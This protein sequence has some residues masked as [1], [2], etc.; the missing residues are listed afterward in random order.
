MDYMFSDCHSLT[1]L[2]LSHFYTNNVEKMNN[3]FKGCS[4]LKYLN[5]SS[6]IFKITSNLNMSNMFS[7]CSSLIELDIKNFAT[8]T[9]AIIDNIFKGISKNIILCNKN[10]A[11][12]KL[13]TS[14]EYKIVKC[15]EE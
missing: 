4:S 11:F 2:D 7:G 15:S 6:F 12:N 14:Y 8:S 13:I 10:N 1:S 3:M 5:I 9:N